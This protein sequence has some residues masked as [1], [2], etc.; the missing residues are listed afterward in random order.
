MSKSKLREPFLSA[1]KKIE[2]LQKYNRY[3][4]AFI[5][6]SVVRGEQDK[7]S[8]LDVM[9]IVDEDNNCKEI[10][11]PI[12]NGIKLDI[13]FRSLA[14]IK[15]INDDVVKKGER[16]PMLAES[17]IVFDKKGE[18]KKLKQTYSNMRA[19]ATPEDFQQIHFMLYHSDNKAKRN[20]ESD[21]ATALL[22][23]SININ[24]I[25]KYHYHINGKWWLSNKRILADLRQWDPKMARLV[26]RFVE[27]SNVEKKYQIWSKIL[28]YVAKPIGG[29]KEI[30]EI[31]CN[32]KTCK[33]DLSLLTS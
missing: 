13:T 23:L 25:L 7:N 17:I 31:N 21:K 19:K 14:Q 29:R 22:A 2:E 4:A 5:F 11:H 33:K 1:Y 8:D 30:S 3:Q 6:G 9:V 27:T 16:L 18:L 26:E 28:D 10:N 24:N 20:L 32:C 15:E 12:I